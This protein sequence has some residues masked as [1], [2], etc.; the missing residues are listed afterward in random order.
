MNGGPLPLQRALGVLT[1]LVDALVAAHRADVIHRDLK[2]QN[3]LLRDDTARGADDADFVKVLDFGISKIRGPDSSTGLTTEGTSLGTPE[4]M[5][6]EQVVDEDVDH[7]ADI[8][9]L[10]VVAY[11]LLTGEPPF[12]GTTMEVM[13]AHVVRQPPTPSSVRDGLPPELDAVILRC[14]AKTPEDRFD[15]ATELAGALAAIGAA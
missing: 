3:I 9:S 5:A 12:S 6:P 7:R 13:K 1:Q 2:P 10:G 8:Y 14:M 4:Y 15:D 11:E